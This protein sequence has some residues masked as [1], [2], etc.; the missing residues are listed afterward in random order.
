V[1]NTVKAKR[2]AYKRSPVNLH[3]FAHDSDFVKQIT[4][5]PDLEVIIY[6]EKVVE[7]FRSLFGYDQPMQQLTY[8]T[9]FSLGDF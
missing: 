6:N 7:V 5:Y 2:N 3:E 9:V 1:K 4:T 8:D